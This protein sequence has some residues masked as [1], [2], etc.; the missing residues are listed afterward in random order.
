[1]RKK[2]LSTI[3]VTSMIATSLLVGCGSDNKSKT[4][5]TSSIETTMDE[6]SS[7]EETTLE[8]TTSVEEESSTIEESTTSA[9]DTSNEDTS[10]VEEESTS[11]V[12]EV[13]TTTKAPET[14]TSKKPE[15]T[16]A[17]E[18]TTSKKEPTTKKPQET[19][20]TK[21]QETTTSAPKVESE[22]TKKIKSFHLAK[23]PDEARDLWL[24]TVEGVGWV[25]EY[26]PTYRDAADNVD[27]PMPD[28]NDTLC[29]GDAPCGHYPNPYTTLEWTTRKYWADK[30][31]ATVGFY[32]TGPELRDKKDI[33]LTKQIEEA[34]SDLP[35]CCHI[36]NEL[37]HIG[38]YDWNYVYYIYYFR[39]CAYQEH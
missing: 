8:P 2:L 21:P 14:T 26:G 13:E 30:D 15:S 32:I 1:M 33:E 28:C 5:A 39:Y 16:T 34:Y 7:V 29:F 9:E 20:T 10:K 4:D 24:K 3:L 6:S 19:T 36:Y 27:P 11:K 31:E 12:V 22:L 18:T 23:Y 17:K 38:T 37:L 25:T 35:D